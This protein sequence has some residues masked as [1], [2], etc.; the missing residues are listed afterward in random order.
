MGKRLKE[1]FDDYKSAFNN[2]NEA[3]Q[4]AK[5]NLEIDGAIKRFELC[6]ELSWKLM[7][8][9]LANLGIICRNPRDCFKQAYQNDLIENEDT[10]L[11]MIDCR[12]QLV[13]TYTFE[14]SRKIFEKIKN[15]YVKEFE[16][17]FNKINIEL[18]D[19]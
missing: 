18:N 11:D 19:L 10:W 9:Y 2:L 1:I 13:H 6:Y 15:D 7:K 4:N 8:E 5:T 14:Q 12:N 3:A 17:I 16:K